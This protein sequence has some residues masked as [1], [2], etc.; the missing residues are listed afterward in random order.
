LASA[1]AISSQ[2]GARQTCHGAPARIASP[3]EL[4]P[5]PS[6]SEPAPLKV[7][8]SCRVS[9]R[10]WDTLRVW[11]IDSGQIVELQCDATGLVPLGFSPD[12][13]YLA[14]AVHKPDRDPDNHVI[15]PGSTAHS[16]LLTRIVNPGP[17]HMPPLAT[18]VLNQEA[19]DL[20]TAWI[21]GSA[22]N[23]QSYA[24]WQ[25]SYFGSTNAPG[26]GPLEDPDGD[27][28]RNQLEYLSGTNPL[29]PGDAW[30]IRFSAT[31]ENAEI[32]FTRIANRGF[33][34]QWT[35]NVSA[36]SS[37]KPLDVPANNLVFGI[38]NTVVAVEDT[39]TNG[40]AKYY[41]VRVFEP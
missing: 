18:S 25:Q 20:V 4:Q 12:G 1:E 8:S 30:G 29:Q 26:S 16:A 40:P 28:A 21:T 10:A 34:V 14:A 39:L 37:W 35:T 41:R 17:Y 2:E 11:N 22:T 7:S 9:L 13:K 27:G 36:G 24:D 33:E 6:K 15:T 32:D 31:G 38:T 23:Y 19:I 3:S 5:A